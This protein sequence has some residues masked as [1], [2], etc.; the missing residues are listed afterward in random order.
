ML[1]CIVLYNVIL[2]YDYYIILYYIILNCVS[3]YHI[4]LHYVS[5]ILYYIYYIILCFIYIL[6]HYIIS[7][8]IIYH[9][10]YIIYHMISYHIL[11]YSYGVETSVDYTLLAYVNIKLEYSKILKSKGEMSPFFVAFFILK[12]I[13]KLRFPPSKSFFMTYIGVQVLCCIF[14]EYDLCYMI[15]SNII[16]LIGIII[17]DS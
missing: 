6:L 7:Y 14:M 17:C 3:L 15:S 8:H 9:I 13:I 1:I 4:I 11:Y 16:L 5:F 12:I 2:Y 10:S